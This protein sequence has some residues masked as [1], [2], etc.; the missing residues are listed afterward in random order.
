M[1]LKDNV[2]KGTTTVGLVCKDGI[3]LAADKRATAGDLI[4]NQKTEKIQTVSDNIALTMA[5]TVS[6][7]QL[8]IKVLTA[9]LKLKEIRSNK[10]SN[11]KAAA[12]LMANMVYSNI[13]RMSMIPGVTHFLMAGKDDSGFSLYDLFADGSITLI[14]DYISS[15]SGSVMAYG[16]LEADYNKNLTVEEGIKLAVRA[17]N[18]ALSR[19]VNSGNGID[20]VTITK[21]GLERM[22]TRV[23]KTKVDL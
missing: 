19:D 3:V 6:D 15:G 20:V 16:L 9:E 8:L 22:P 21:K 10:I 17:I 1:D 5:G 7:A 18:S 12:N 2:Q 14:D 23:L 4:V 13:R 11:V